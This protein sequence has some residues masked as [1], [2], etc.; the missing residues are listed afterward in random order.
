MR[1]SID[2]LDREVKLKNES[3]NSE[4]SVIKD[5]KKNEVNPRSHG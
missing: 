2:Q 5:N 4:F 1:D 3:F